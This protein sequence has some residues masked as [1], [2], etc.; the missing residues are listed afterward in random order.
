MKVKDFVKLLQQ[1]NQELEIVFW[2][3]LMDDNHWGCILSTDDVNKRELCICP[4]IEE[5]EWRYDK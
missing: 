4:T 2:N 5:G 3:E 1:E